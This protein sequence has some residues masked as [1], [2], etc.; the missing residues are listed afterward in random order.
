MPGLY[1]GI[2]G[3]PGIP[4]GLLGA[5]WGLLRDS[6]GLPKPPGAPGASWEPPGHFLGGFWGFLRAP[7]ASEQL[8]DLT[9]ISWGTLGAFSQWSCVFAM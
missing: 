8:L 7:G 5:S 1:S 6:W 3:A 2:S 9:G 4:L